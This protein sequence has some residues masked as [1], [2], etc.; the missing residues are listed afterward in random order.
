MLATGIYTG[1]VRHTRTRPRRL[2][3]RH[4]C[5]WLGLDVDTIADVAGRFWLFSY[6]RSNIISFHDR[7]HGDATAPG[8]RAQVE[9]LLASAGLPAKPQKIILFCMPRVVGYGFNP[10]S[11]YFCADDAGALQ[12][13]IYEVHNTFGQ[14]HSYVVPAAG[15]EGRNVQQCQKTFYV[16]PFMDIDLSYTFTLD[17]SREKLLLAIQASDKDGP[18]IFTSV[19]A[20]RKEMSNRNL[21]LTWLSHP[22]QTVKVIAA[23]HFHAARLWLKGIKLR[24][25]PSPP[26]NPSTLG[27]LRK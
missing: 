11:I 1:K 16:S 8:L 3:L 4:D 24:T 9:N 15:E 25:R 23:I 10:L 12:S 22:L 13:V 20:A 7:D 6:N 27:Q 2:A 5:F 14:R 21:L 19:N 17:T 26:E 18:I